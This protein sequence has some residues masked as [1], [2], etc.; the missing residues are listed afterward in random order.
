MLYAWISKVELSAGHIPEGIKA[1]ERAQSLAPFLPMLKA[2]RR[3][4][5]ALQVVLMPRD[6]DSNPVASPAPASRPPSLWVL[7]PQP[8]SPFVSR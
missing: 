4:Y 5:P 8:D 7:P 1:F 3:E 6:S 2:L